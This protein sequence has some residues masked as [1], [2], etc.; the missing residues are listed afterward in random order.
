MVVW[1]VGLEEGFAV[2]DLK[3]KVVLHLGQLQ[4]EFVVAASLAAV[5]LLQEPAS[6]PR[7]F[8]HDAEQPE[9][10]REVWGVLWVAKMGEV[11]EVACGLV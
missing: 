2:K 3:W 4:L 11:L 10:V 9:V 7:P 5:S 6:F 8:F 1:E